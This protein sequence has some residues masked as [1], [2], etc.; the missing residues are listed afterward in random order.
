MK[1]RGKDDRPAPGALSSEQHQAI[2]R[3]SENKRLN[4]W[5]V[6]WET[7]KAD[8]GLEKWFESD[9]DKGTRRPKLFPV[10]KNDSWKNK[11]GSSSFL[12]SM[13]AADETEAAEAEDDLYM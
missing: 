9:D 5:E 2:V 1:P 12:A 10:L 4:A 11:R 7:V 3:Y 13:M 6:S 8:G